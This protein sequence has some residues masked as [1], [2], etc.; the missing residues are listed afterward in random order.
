M[1][2]G[3][4]PSQAAFCLSPHPQT[5]ATQ[6]SHPRASPG[7]PGP[8]SEPAGTVPRACAGKCDAK[9]S[10]ASSTALMWSSQAMSGAQSWSHSWPR[11]ARRGAPNLRAEYPPSAAL[12]SASRCQP[13]TVGAL[14]GTELPKAM[15]SGCNHASTD[16]GKIPLA[17][18][19]AS[20]C[21]FSTCTGQVLSPP[22]T[23]RPPASAVETGRNKVAT[24]SSSEMVACAS[25]APATSS[26][27]SNQRF[28]STEVRNG[29]VKGRG[30]HLCNFSSAASFLQPL[31]PRRGRVHWERSLARTSKGASTSPRR[32]SS[33]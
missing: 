29:D 12:A 30:D 17:L 5:S 23:P 1:T 7:P 28:A 8:D 18:A 16:D 11:A 22:S 2:N 9:H 15:K 3:R 33:K 21:N 32:S 6:T 19:T 31:P 24:C 26:S 20:I 27:R 25:C 14:D 10:C 4:T 13:D